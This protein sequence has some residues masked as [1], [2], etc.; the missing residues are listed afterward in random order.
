MLTFILTVWCFSRVLHL[1]VRVED[2]ESLQLCSGFYQL[3]SRFPLS[4]IAAFFS[5]CFGR[6][7]LFVTGIILSLLCHT[8]VNQMASES[9]YNFVK[10][11]KAKPIQ[12]FYFQ[13]CSC[14]GGK[15]DRIHHQSKPRKS[16]QS[17]IADHLPRKEQFV[18]SYKYFTLFFWVYQSG[19]NVT[20]IV[21]ISF[22]F[23]WINKSFILRSIWNGFTELW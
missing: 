21:K 19:I 13:S 22:T 14:W 12:R 10:H 3:Q 23:L 2:V 20:L 17:E 6:S 18:F 11:I 8:K 4:E 16:Q 9:S 15:P 5:G 1:D 7:W